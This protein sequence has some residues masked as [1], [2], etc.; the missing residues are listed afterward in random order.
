MGTVRKTITV[1]HQ[2]ETW[3]KS[4]IEDGGYTNDS[5]YI[6]DLLR[7]DQEQNTKLAALRQAVREGLDSGAGMKTVAEIWTEA[8]TLNA[9]KDA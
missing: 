8:E 5:E 9:A 3:I 4:R 7:R 6:R 2:Q 1:T